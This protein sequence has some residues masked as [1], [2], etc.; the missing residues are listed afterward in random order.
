MLRYSSHCPYTSELELRGFDSFVAHVTIWRNQAKIFVALT[1]N[2]MEKRFLKIL[3]SNFFDRM[4][5]G[6][7]QWGA[8][9]QGRLE[10]WSKI[11]PREK[12]DGVFFFLLKTAISE[13]QLLEN[14]SLLAT[15]FPLILKV[16]HLRQKGTGIYAPVVWSSCHLPRADQAESPRHLSGTCTRPTNRRRVV[17]PPFAGIVGCYCA[18]TYRCWECYGTILT[19]DTLDMQ[20]C[21]AFLFWRRPNSAGHLVRWCWSNGRSGWQ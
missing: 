14:S 10:Q 15:N 11:L 13:Q 1:T 4:Q 20:R 12:S 5:V 8:V 16:E 17:R 21:Y 18:S 2:V 9:W 7:V 19:G 3:W 6:R